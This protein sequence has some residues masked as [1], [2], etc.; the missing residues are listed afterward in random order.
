MLCTEATKKCRVSK[1]NQSSSHNQENSLNQKYV[2]RAFEWDKVANAINPKRPGLLGG[3]FLEKWSLSCQIFFQMKILV[4]HMKAEM[5]SWHLD[6]CFWGQSRATR[7]HYSQKCMWPNLEKRPSF[8]QFS[9]KL[10]DF[11]LWNI[12][13]IGFF[14]SSDH[15][16][17]EHFRMRCLKNGWPLSA[18]PL[19]KIEG[20]QAKSRGFLG[21]I[22]Q[23]F[24]A[25]CWKPF[26]EVEF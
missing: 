10:S 5:F 11:F 17:W 16:F 23:F 7:W 14:F 20:I 25:D 1:C 24:D 22:H 13:Q 15:S 9:S 26:Y 2:L 21:L 6:Q 3:D 8:L 19:M 4:F 12:W 18:P